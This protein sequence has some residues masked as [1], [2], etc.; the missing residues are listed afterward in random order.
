MA[1]VEQ[2]PEFKSQY[3][4]WHPAYR[5]VPF[6]IQ[7]SHFF[8]FCHFYIYSHVYTLFGPP[9]SAPFLLVW[10][11]DSYTER[12]LA[13]LLCT[14]VLQPTLVHLYQTSSLL[15]SPHLIVAS[16]SLRLLCL[17]LYSEDINHIKVLGFLP[18]PY[19]S[20]VHPPL[21]VW[22]MS[23]NINAF[24]LG[25]WSAYKEECDFWPSEPGWLCKRSCSPVPSIY[26]WM[27]KF[28]SSLWLNKIPLCT[29]TTFS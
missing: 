20:Y 18:F 29:N 24:V 22:P 4:L 21:S 14:C 12:F 9:I 15:R 23:N 3:K 27:K 19:F 17:L 2:S 7:G 1:Q 8:L 26:L 5:R 13:L 25:L 28:H 10:D 16:G 11:K 6:L